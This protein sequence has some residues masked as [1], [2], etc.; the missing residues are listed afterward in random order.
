MRLSFF[1]EEIRNL[2]EDADFAIGRIGAAMAEQLKQKIATLMSAKALSHIPNDDHQII[3]SN[4]FPIY[5]IGL[6]DNLQIYC[7]ADH[8][9]AY[10]KTATKQIDWPNVDYIQIFQINIPNGPQ[11]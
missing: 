3:D 10:P 4:P 2:C 9:N 11:F 6:A 1:N 7:K 8:T 5:R